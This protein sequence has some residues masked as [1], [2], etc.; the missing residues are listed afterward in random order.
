MSYL[1]AVLNNNTA[2]EKKHLINIISYGKKLGYDT[3][4]YQAELKKLSSKKKIKTVKKISKKK[5]IEK[6]YAKK[7]IIAN[8]S[9][10]KY[11]IKKVYTQ[12]NMIIIDFNKHV[13]KKDIDYNIDKTKYSNL[14]LFD[15]K[16]YFKDARPT[17]LAINGI[18][19]IFIIQK[20]KTILHIKV[21]DKNRLKPIYIINNKRIIIKFLNIKT[22]SKKS[23]V[24]YKEKYERKIVLIDP[25]HGGKDSGA[26][27]PYKRYEKHVV[28]AIAKDL[29]YHLKRRGYKVYLTRT[30]DKF[31]TLRNRTKKANRVNADIFISIHANSIAKSKAKE[32]KGIE[33]FFLSP[34]RSARAKRVAAKENSSDVRAMSN[35][36]KNSFLTVLNQSKITAS[37]KLA[38]DIQ[39]N[40]L[41]QLKKHYKYIEDSGVREG[42]FWVLVGAQMPS[43]LIE[44]GYISNPM[45]SR[46]LYNKKYQKILAE[47]IANGVDSYFLK[48]P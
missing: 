1:R 9:N 27:G 40:M 14:Y 35:A 38:I 32:V 30:N 11:S 45:E 17:K 6:E 47:G 29:A 16:G 18:D 20:N 12:K 4:K 25:G 22:T 43:I 24:T 37:N 48:N 33:T 26:I 19:K 34:A 8:N 21:R 42:P 2:L 28:L 5:K 36:T 41:Y 10:S 44:V 39:Q 46:R 3:K 7:S 23:T 15:I 31:I 13:T